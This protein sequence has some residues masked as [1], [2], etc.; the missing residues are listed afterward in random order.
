MFRKIL[1]GI[2]ALIVLGVAMIAVLVIRTRNPY[3][4]EPERLGPKGDEVL[5]PISSVPNA[6]N[7]LLYARHDKNPY[8]IHFP[9][10]NEY[11]HKSNTT[12]RIIKSYAV[13]VS[14]YYPEL[15]GKFNPV[16]AN[17]PNCNGWCGGYMRAFVEVD[18]SAQTINARV[19]EQ[20][21]QQRQS[22][23]PLYQF[24]DLA[25][26]FGL[27]EHFQIR[28]PIAEKRLNGKR[29]LTKEYFVR[30]DENGGIKYLFECLPYAPSP[31]CGVQ[32]NLAARP[33]LLV[34]I[35][36]G[37]H[38]MTEW[39]SIIP[40]VSSKIASWGLVKIATVDK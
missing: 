11:I 34:D 8:V 1:I 24:E 30:R 27:D 13:S 29:N 7:Y 31:G 36:F 4:L 20:L 35:R 9:L 19:L 32:F 28:Y 15:N 40:A 37:R 2:G 26:A 38:L 21:A 18:K 22:D 33:E 10:P 16:N 5:P 3:G 14:M 39:E 23:S 6:K 17:L 25:P 12:S